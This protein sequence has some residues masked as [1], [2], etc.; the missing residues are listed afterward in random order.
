MI[1]NLFAKKCGKENTAIQSKENL[2]QI[3]S[4]KLQQFYYLLILSPMLFLPTIGIVTIILLNIAYNFSG[5]SLQN[6]VKRL[7]GNNS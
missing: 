7:L 4:H 2:L 1:N 6:L 5:N 3:T